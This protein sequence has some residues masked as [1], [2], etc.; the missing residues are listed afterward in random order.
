MAIDFQVLGKPG[1]D[2]A[3]WL[4]IDSGNSVSR[5][6]FDCG[7]G[8]LSDLSLSD[9]QATDHLFFSHL[10]MDH[11][12]GFDSFFRC[13]FNRDTKPNMVWGPA[14]TSTILHHRFRGFLWN[15]HEGQPG[16][17]LVNDVHADRV[18]RYRFELSD[19]FQTRHLDKTTKPSNAILEEKDFSVQAI[20]LEHRGPC[21]GYLVRENPRLNILTDR[22]SGMGLLPGPWLQDLKSDSKV[23]EIEIEGKTWNRHELRKKLL[24]ET[25]G[26]SIAYLTDFLLDEP[27]FVLLTS[28]LSGCDTV[29]C[30]AQY[31]HS[32][33]ELALRNYHTT[34]KLVSQLA[35]R[36]KIGRLVL[37]HL[38]DRYTVADRAEMLNECRAIF[39][40]TTFPDNWAI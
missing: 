14:E 26:E 29:L 37:F 34:T 16:T 22:L 6:L 28:L 8:C 38:S 40:N 27:A 1:R 31:R 25:P 32:D 3:L 36:A 15:L 12:G 4:R 9:I 11:V 35:V 13:T 20:Q 7:D 10:H 39:P 19:A 30:E 21:L 18:D 23:S 17:W 5:L 24:V 2:N 33:L